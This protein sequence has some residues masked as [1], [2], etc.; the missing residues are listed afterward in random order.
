[1]PQCQVGSHTV[2]VCVSPLLPAGRTAALPTAISSVASKLQMTERLL[3]PPYS[4]LLTLL[5]PLTPCTTQ[6]SRI[7]STR[8]RSLHHFTLTSHIPT[9]CHLSNMRSVCLFLLA[10]LLLAGSGSAQQ[11][12]TLSFLTSSFPH[13]TSV[14][15][16]STDY[17]YVLNGSTLV[18]F[19][20]PRS[21]VWTIDLSAS[22][23][24][25][26]A[27]KVD[28]AGQIY[29]TDMQLGAVVVF[30]SEGDQ[31]AV[32][33]GLSGAVSDGKRLSPA[34]L[35][36]DRSAALYVVDTANSR[37]VVFN[38]YGNVTQYLDIKTGINAQQLVDVVV[39]SL[40]M[41]YVS[42]VGNSVIVVLNGQNNTE[43]ALW[44]VRPSQGLGLAIDSSN[45]VYVAD[46]SNNTIL[47]FNTAG[48]LQWYETWD[49]YQLAPNWLA[50]NSANQLFIADVAHSTVGVL[51]G[52]I[53]PGTILSVI[54]G[55]IGP[56]AVAVSNTSLL[57]IVNSLPTNI[58]AVQLY[59]AQ[60]VTPL[61]CNRI[62]FARPLALCCIEV[63]SPTCVCFFLCCVLW[64]ATAATMRA[65]S[66]H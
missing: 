10:I 35:A 9:P 54:S 37:V 32:Y 65:P 43:V 33:D 28:A 20:A 39:D 47:V 11:S 19:N 56:L 50:L 45:F 2:S 59:V 31:L 1:M 51:T 41:V 8:I 18:E 49:S 17:L 53:L 34:G 7:H 64:S 60:A 61:P 27:M 36:F 30:D 15:V 38:G 44:S 48:Q 22:L 29:V 21:V 16:D 23:R 5:T 4:A 24:S 42:D 3:S 6:P 63:H 57:V 62:Q 14:A 13:L 55:Q 66:M 40:G 12:P 46:S 58:Q 25:P 52:V 26:V